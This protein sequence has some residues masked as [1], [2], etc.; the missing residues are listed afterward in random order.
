VVHSW[1]FYDI[2]SWAFFTLNF[3]FIL[4]G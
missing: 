2:A 3:F 1:R 4:L